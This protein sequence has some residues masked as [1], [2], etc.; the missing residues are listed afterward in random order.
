M[1]ITEEKNGV[2]PVENNVVPSGN[3]DS[4]FFEDCTADNPIDNNKFLFVTK[5]SS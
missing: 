5:G 1:E 2:A 4:N 3:N